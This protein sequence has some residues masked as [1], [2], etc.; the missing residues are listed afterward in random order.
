MFPR[1]R[2]ISLRHASFYILIY[3][4]SFLVQLDDETMAQLEQ[5]APARNRARAEFVRR[6]I[7]SALHQ[8][9][10][11][12]IRDS[13]L[14]DPQVLEDGGDWDDPLEWNPKATNE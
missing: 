6:A 12:R 7:K 9:E 2:K 13:Y 5:V 10:F 11:D 8:S 14:K 3:M 1:R 4:K